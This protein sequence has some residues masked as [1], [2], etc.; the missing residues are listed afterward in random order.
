LFVTN[1]KAVPMAEMTFDE[2]LRELQDIRRKIDEVRGDP[3]RTDELAKL[4]EERLR[5]REILEV[6]RRADPAAE[7]AILHHELD[8]LERLLDAPLPDLGL[9]LPMTAMDGQ[10]G[11][12][13][14]GMD[15][16][17]PNTALKNEGAAGY[18]SF[19]DALQR[20]EYIKQRLIDLDSKE[21]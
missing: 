18:R 15:Y 3:N 2:A 9:A 21:S 19:N 8:G 13:T 11:V 12:G 20:I 1:K 7:I 14:V 5:L 10:G 17:T 4:T 16:I 6:H